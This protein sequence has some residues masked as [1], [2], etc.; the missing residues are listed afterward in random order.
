MNYFIYFNGQEVG[1]MTKEQLIA[2]PVDMNTP[3]SCE[4]SNWQPLSS[5]PELMHMLYMKKG[6]SVATN[7]SKRVL[8]G[9]LAIIIGGLGIQYFVIG[10]VGAG[11]LTIL[12]TMVTCGLWSF[13]TLV[14]GILMLTMSDREFEQKYVQTTS[15]FPLF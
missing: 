1:P 4:G 6:Q 7:D 9:I 2:Y 13:I 14:Q 11:L 15:T 10:K 3:V 12:L 8:C 5:Y